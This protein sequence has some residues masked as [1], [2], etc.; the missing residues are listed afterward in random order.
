MSVND[1]VGLNRVAEANKPENVFPGRIELTAFI[2][3]RVKGN[4][5]CS[6]SD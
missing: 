5:N 2:D 6:D 4:V 1:I 3:Q